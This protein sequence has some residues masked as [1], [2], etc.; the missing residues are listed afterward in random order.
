MDE[1][2]TETERFSAEEL[3]NDHD[4]VIAIDNARFA[5]G[6]VDDSELTYNEKQ[7]LRAAR[8]K[9][10]DLSSSLVRRLEDDYADGER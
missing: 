9:L 5:L 8:R 10:G 1:A 6:D 2:T 3:A 7:M 4:A